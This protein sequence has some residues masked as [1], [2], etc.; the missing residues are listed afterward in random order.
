[1]ENMFKLQRYYAGSHVGT[2]ITDVIQPK[3]QQLHS[4]STT[5]FF[6]LF[7]ANIS[8]FPLKGQKISVLTCMPLCEH[9]YK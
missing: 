7:L 9:I 8:P 3:L 6:S 4:G 5:T 1:M 2:I